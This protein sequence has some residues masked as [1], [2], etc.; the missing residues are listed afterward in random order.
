M[1]PWH[2]LPFCLAV[3]ALRFIAPAG[4][5]I[6]RSRRAPATPGPGLPVPHFSRSRHRG[7]GWVLVLRRRH[8][9]CSSRELCTRCDLP[10][11]LKN[12]PSAGETLK[13]V[14]ISCRVSS[15][16]STF[17][18]VIMVA[19]SVLI[20]LALLPA[21]ALGSIIEPRAKSFDYDSLTLR[22]VGARNTLV[23]TCHLS[24]AGI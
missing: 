9:C 10:D 19:T 15:Q 20:R 8:W 5:T 23:S 22:E 14:Q 24:K 4:V 21:V 7:F 1:T 16:L 2:V 13:F 11:K 6:R 3:G 17:S 18:Q 12:T